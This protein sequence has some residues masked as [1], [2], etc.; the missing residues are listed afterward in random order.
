M[1]QM[2]KQSVSVA[3]VGNPNVGKSTVFNH[4]T[5][6]NR[7]TGN[8]PGKTVDHFGS[9]VIYEGKEYRFVDL[10]GTYS[11][12]AVSKEEQVTCDF[13]A[14]EKPDVTVCVINAANLER[15]L[16]FLF[17]VRLLSPNCVAC[18]N[19][20]DEAKA[21][22]I[23]IDVQKLER[24][25]SMPVVPTIARNGTGIG[26][27]MKTIADVASKAVEWSQ[28]QSDVSMNALGR[29]E[30]QISQDF[31]EASAI[32]AKVTHKSGR[33]SRDLTHRI[34]S[35]VTSR[36]V[37]VPLMLLLLGVVFFITLYLSNYPSDLLFNLF[38]IAESR[39]S[40][41]LGFF[42]VTGWV[43]DILILGPSL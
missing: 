2:D 3:L 18:L 10:P 42:R 12:R 8:W 37:G 4:L 33:R 29:T 19:L 39:L 24:E 14:N 41:A 34:D 25:L 1:E 36:A 28:P 17:Q 26:I 31:S 21:K 11:L 9:T 38:S 13:I 16:S 23:T 6:L 22:G 35:I 40:Q 5:G 27:L 43:H 15:N 7:H 30:S 32:S 20:L